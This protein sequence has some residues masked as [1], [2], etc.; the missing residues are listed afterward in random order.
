MAE[1][2]RLSDLCTPGRPNSIGF[3]RYL[4]AALVVFSHA[5]ALGGF[6]VEPLWLWSRKQDTLGSISVACFLIL[7]GFLVAHSFATAKS[8]PRFLWHRFLRILPAFWVCLAVVAFGFGGLHYWRVHHTLDGFLSNR[9]D[10]P[11]T[12]LTGNF[13]LQMKQ[14]GIAG[15]L[16]GIPFQ[17]HFDGSLW[18]LAYQFRFYLVVGLVGLLGLLTRFR[19]VGQVVILVVLG[20]LILRDTF[21]PKLLPVGWADAQT[22]K[23]GLWFCAGVTFYYFADSIPVHWTLFG[24]SAALS[25]LSLHYGFY[26]L[27]GPVAISYSVFWLALRLP[28][29]F[30]DRPGDFSYGLYLFAFPVQQTLA[31]YGVQ[32]RGV[33]LYF[34]ASMV[35]ATALAVVC[36]YAIEKPAL[37]LKHLRPFARKA[38]PVAVT[39]PPA[40]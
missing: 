6:G 5:Y 9:I 10:S 2:T 29:S 32:K 34:A 35:L 1:R 28:F 23:L 30:W 37:A 3:L 12:Y 21:A 22:M 39:P 4:L 16:R 18:T 27:A 19:R 24:V 14:G 11:I 38:A 25:L 31:V 33:V 8:L 40:P 13:F 20:A 15:L 36:H 7:S 26:R 17:V